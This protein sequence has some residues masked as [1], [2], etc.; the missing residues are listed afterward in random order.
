MQNE[1]NTSK[2]SNTYRRD[3]GAVLKELDESIFPAVPKSPPNIPKENETPSW[4]RDLQIME[5][6][7]ERITTF[8][9]PQSVTADEILKRQ[10]MD[11]PKQ[12]PQTLSGKD[13]EF[14]KKGKSTDGSESESEDVKRREP[15]ISFPNNEM[16][17]TS[18]FGV[19]N[20][21]SFVSDNSTGDGAVA[22][23]FRID[24]FYNLSEGLCGML[25]ESTDDLF[26]ELDKLPGSIFSLGLDVFPSEMEPINP[27][28]YLLFSGK[29][30]I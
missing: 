5:M 20:Q 4:Q 8:I 28:H 25:Y 6:S 15:P 2:Y 7:N 21:N 27:D 3:L 30:K 13:T 17:V 19:D 10:H 23:E 9:E 29:A 24:S 1:G 14:V 12:E 26:V 16:L 11:L 22:T 18:I